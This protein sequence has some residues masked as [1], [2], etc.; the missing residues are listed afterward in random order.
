LAVGTLAQAPGDPR[1][2]A[3]PAPVNTAKLKADIAALAG[4]QKAVETGTSATRAA[5]RDELRAL[6]KALNERPDPLPPPR[7]SGPGGTTGPKVEPGGKPVD[8]LRYAMNL[9]RDNDI[10]AAVAVFQRIDPRSLLAEDRAFVR[11]M[12]A[13]CLRKLNRVTE[14]EVIY[15]EVADSKE[16]E[17]VAGCAVWQL[18][19]IRSQRELQTQL[20]VLRARA[21]TK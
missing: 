9:F 6:I 17:F 16:D 4:E 15:R 2:P 18:S 5:L 13:C 3:Q 12:T 20:E 11:Y 21:K 1:L 8:E 14:A 7:P 10:E 19:L